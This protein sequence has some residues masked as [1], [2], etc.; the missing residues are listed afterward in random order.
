MRCSTGDGPPPAQTGV[1]KANAMQAAASHGARVIV[2]PPLLVRGHGT[3]A[4]AGCSSGPRSNRVASMQEPFFQAGAS[5][6]EW[7]RCHH[8]EEGAEREVDETNSW[9]PGRAA[10]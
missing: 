8:S 6:A 2:L 9:V 4:A 3:A 10:D 7:S 1:C 5:L